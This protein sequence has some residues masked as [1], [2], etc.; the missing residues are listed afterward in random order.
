MSAS[1]PYPAPETSG[2]RTRARFADAGEAARSVLARAA[3]ASPPLTT[4]EWRVLAAVLQLT[5]CYSRLSDRVWKRQL[6][7]AAGDLEDKALQRT[8]R[9][10]NERHLIIWQPSSV[11][12]QPSNV[13]LVPSIR[14]VEADPPNGSDRGVEA[15]PPKARVRGVST[16][17][18]RGADAGPPPK[19]EPEETAPRAGAPAGADAREDGG[20]QEEASD[21]DLRGRAGAIVRHIRERHPNSSVLAVDLGPLRAAIAGALERGCDAAALTGVLA[22][23]VRE[24]AGV[25]LLVALA[26]GADPEDYP[27]GPTPEERE[28]AAQRERERQAAQLE[29]HEQAR[30]HEA[31]AAE[32]RRRLAPYRRRQRIALEEARRIDAPFCYLEG[33]DALE[34]AGLKSGDSGGMP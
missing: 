30:R 10:L 2:A 18:V 11:K 32:E 24:A 4:R 13:G 6:A 8:L 25:G 17:P 14:G 29:A 5:T 3:A 15:D 34:Q 27:A 16:Q 7:A 21:E 9:A 26:R 19:K 23:K 31:A 28:R 1:P 33:G 20:E 12:G 22:E